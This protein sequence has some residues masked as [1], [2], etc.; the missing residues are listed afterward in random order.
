MSKY[1]DFGYGNVSATAVV[2]AGASGI[3][4]YLS[5]SPGKNLTVA[6]RDDALAHGLDIILVWETTA[7][8][9]NEGVT[10]GQADGGL[11]AAEA[12]SLGAPSGMTI[13]AST[14]MDT[15][16]ADVSAY[17]GA[18]NAEVSAAGYVGDV[19]AGFN[20]V[21]DAH[22]AGEAPAPWQTS[23]WSHGNVLSAA[24]LIQNHYSVAIDG[25]DCD[26]S[27]VLHAPNGWRANAVVTADPLLRE[28]STGQKVEDV[29]H[30]LNLC[31]ND[32]DVDG[33]FGSDTERILRVFQDHRE[34]PVTGTTTPETWAALR[35]VAHPTD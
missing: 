10:A 25:V 3:C 9:S 23:A 14:D 31:G 17:H 1:V 8:R 7:T 33:I 34:L 13:Y 29:Q 21:R 19:Y 22:A 26:S 5:N 15:T 16:W 27:D 2:S 12:K 20:V 32:I 24:A 6:G 30:A 28:G 11:A 18:F 35:V 4:R